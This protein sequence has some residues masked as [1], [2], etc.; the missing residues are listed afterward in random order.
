MFTPNAITR[1]LFSSKISIRLSL[2]SVLAPL[3]FV[4]NSPIFAVI[5][6]RLVTA[7]LSAVTAFA[8]SILD[9]ITLLS[10]T[11]VLLM[12]RYFPSIVVVV[13]DTLI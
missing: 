11:V 2:I 10:I 1:K 7:N 6:D 3:V 12:C 8:A 4:L 13:G 9:T 5:A